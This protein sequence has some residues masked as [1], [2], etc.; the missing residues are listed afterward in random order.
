MNFL[1]LSQLP[2]IQAS[3]SHYDAMPSLGV[4]RQPQRVSAFWRRLKAFVY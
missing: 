4:R 2:R 3:R 1:L